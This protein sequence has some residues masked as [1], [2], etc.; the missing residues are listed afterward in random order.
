MALFSY[1]PPVAELLTLGE[2]SSYIQQGAWSYSTLDPA[3]LPWQS[4]IDYGEAVGLTPAH[5]PELIA[6]MKDESLWA[7]WFA[8]EKR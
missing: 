8:E 1:S 7:L 6:L 4:W 3:I 5:I 2:P